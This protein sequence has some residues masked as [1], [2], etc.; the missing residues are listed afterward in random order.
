[1]FKHEKAD[2]DSTLPIGRKKKL[3]IWRIF[4][5]VFEYNNLI[6]ALMITLIQYQFGHVTYFYLLGSPTQY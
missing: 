2:I 4:V 6:T 1:M 5:S 3:K